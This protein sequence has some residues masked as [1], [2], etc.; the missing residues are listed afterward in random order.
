MTTCGRQL[1]PSDSKSQKSVPNFFHICAIKSYLEMSYSKISGCPVP[2]RS[3]LM[4]NLDPSAWSHGVWLSPSAGSQSMSHCHC[5]VAHSCWHFWPSG[6]KLALT[7]LQEQASPEETP[8]S[9][10]CYKRVFQREIFLYSSKG[11][12]GEW[13]DVVP[14]MWQNISEVK[15]DTE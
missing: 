9:D 4:Q 3:S 10:V 8:I 2:S 5:P 12:S 11:T 13:K 7:L 15:S 1:E 6:P 14:M